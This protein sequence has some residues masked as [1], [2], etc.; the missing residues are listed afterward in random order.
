MPL[1]AKNERDKLNYCMEHPDAHQHAG[2]P[3][4]LDTVEEAIYIL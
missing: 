3:G 4:L 1:E 2:L